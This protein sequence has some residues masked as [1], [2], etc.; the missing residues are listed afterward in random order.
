MFYNIFF[1]GK[2]ITLEDTPMVIVAH[3]MGGLLARDALSLCAGRKGETKTKRLITIASPMWGRKELT[4]H[5]VAPA[6]STPSDVWGVWSSRT[7]QSCHHERNFSQCPPL[8]APESQC[9][10]RLFCGM[11]Q[12]TPFSTRNEPLPSEC[13]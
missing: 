1:S 9:L 6:T 11:S 4:F 5:G 7:P 13:N 10:L 3:S 2:V 8:S 12:K